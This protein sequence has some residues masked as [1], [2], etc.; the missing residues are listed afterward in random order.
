MT[1]IVEYYPI[2][3]IEYP[4]EDGKPIAESDQARDY[5]TYAT[6]VLKVHFQNISNVY[7]SVNLFIYYEKG[8][9]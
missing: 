3:P 8:N 1:T 9:P 2:K 7:I 5:L 6:E 4:E